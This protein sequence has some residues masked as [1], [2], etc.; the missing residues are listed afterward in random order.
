MLPLR[1]APRLSPTLGQGCTAPQWVEMSLFLWSPLFL[2]PSLTEQGQEKAV[3][4]G[5]HLLSAAEERDRTWEAGMGATNRS[6]SSPYANV[7]TDTG[8]GEAE[9]P[10]SCPAVGPPAPGST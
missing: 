1:E 4:S 5:S 3:G 9:D 2:T 8:H 6:H 10:G 7:G